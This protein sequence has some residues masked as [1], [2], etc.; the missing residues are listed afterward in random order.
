METQI[1]KSQQTNN[2]LAFVDAEMQSL[3]SALDYCTAMVKSKILPKHYYDANGN[4]KPEAPQMLL[5]VVQAAKEVGMTQ[6]QGIQ[7]LVPVNGMVSIKGDG[8]KALIL[9]SGKVAEWK[10]WTEGEGENFAAFIKARRRDT[11]EEIT[12]SFS[13]SDAKRAGLW[14]DQDTVLRNEKMKHYPWFKYGKRMLRYRALGFIS[15]DLFPD[16]LQG[17]AIEEE[18]RDIDMDISRTD[19]G[20]GVR[21]DAGSGTKQDKIEHSAIKKATSTTIVKTAEENTVQEK[22][23]DDKIPGEDKAPVEVKMPK[24]EYAQ[25]EEVEDYKQMK[26]HVCPASRIGEMLKTDKKGCE[27]YMDAACRDLN[28]GFTGFRHMASIFSQK[29]SIGWCEQLIRKIR[30]DEL[31]QYVEEL[32]S[33]GTQ[34]EVAPSNPAPVNQPAKTQPQ[35][36]EAVERDFN[37]QFEL[38]K[39]LKDKGW[40]TL[41]IAKYVSEE[42]GLDW[43]AQEFIAKANRKQ[44]DQMLNS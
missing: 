27:D 2:T 13:I 9:A 30:L 11:N 39:E 14:I 7:Q 29:V 5:I 42:L 35:A 43:T 15:R 23:Q 25:F 38:Q 6:M 37:Q 17:V 33:N 12:S 22:V 18:A 3:K 20:T 16:V 19:A 4:P 40:T 41:K 10:E 44:I 1:V 8:A 31:A 21:V 24:T 32:S 26:I 34:Q 28:K 36:G